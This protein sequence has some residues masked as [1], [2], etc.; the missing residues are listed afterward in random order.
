MP[1]SLKNASQIFQRKMDSIFKDLNH[2][3]LVY[4]DDIFVF[5]KAI[6]QHKDDIL[7]VTQRCINRSII[8]GKKKCIYAEQKIKFLGLEIKVG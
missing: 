7:A 5:F 1:F 4:I 2:C 6:E 3:C 8:L